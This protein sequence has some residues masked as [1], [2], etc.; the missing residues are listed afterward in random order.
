MLFIFGV[1]IVRSVRSCR[2][3]RRVMLEEDTVIFVA[4]I[5]EPTEVETPPAYAEKTDAAPEGHNAT[6]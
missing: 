6:N 1:L 3:E 2:Q 4:D 5:K